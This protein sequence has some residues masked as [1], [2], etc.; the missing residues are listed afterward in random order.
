MP[1]IRAARTVLL[2]SLSLAALSAPLTLGA[3]PAGQAPQGSARQVDAPLS[4]EAALARFHDRADL[5]RAQE[6]D[7]ARA[8]HASEAAK[9]L[10][11]PKVDVAALQIEGRKSLSI[12]ANVP[13]LGMSVPFSLNED[14]DIG[15]PRA[16]VTAVWPIYTGGAVAAEQNVL[17][18]K[19]AEARAA[20][21]AL[22]AA[23]DAGLALVYWRTQLARSI[24]T[25]R[26]NA[27]AD[28]EEALR[29]AKSF[30]KEGLIS[31]IERMTVEVSRDAARRALSAA[32]TEARVAETEL[33][34]A[35]RDKA[36]PQLETPL[37]VLTGELGTLDDWKQRAQGASPVLAQADALAD[38]ADQGVNAAKSAYKPQIFA[39]GMKNLVKHYLTIPEPDWIAGIGV[40]FTLWD[41]R[42]R[43]SSVAAAESLRE[44]AGAARA[45][46]EN[47]VLTAVEVA[48]MRTL[49]AR[50]EYELSAS[51]VALAR[52]NL[53]MREKSFA[54]GLS[55]ALDVSS[56]RTQMIGA[57]IAR[58][59]AAYKFVAG[60]A[61]LHSA[62]GAM[63]D[64]TASLSRQ[65]FVPVR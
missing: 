39:F 29:R 18:G 54:Q 38:Q 11:G 62:A 22:Y 15:G 5:F 4:F 19:A 12:N 37:F 13:V 32:G 41:N 27:L 34:R 58:A 59:T 10:G 65:D 25:L 51:T 28:E 43:A 60:W 20:R 17:K 30:E 57:E 64:F 3:A 53:R 21:S 55:T 61:V 14:F 7:V 8:E 40:K 49:E 46:A 36:A 24:E 26:R 47:D 31:K 48:W 45:E 35:L 16:A 1:P 44:K 2:M 6:A 63:S 52:E 42:D 23:E 33:A 50:N 56:A 9:W